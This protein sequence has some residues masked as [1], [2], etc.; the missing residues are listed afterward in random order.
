MLENTSSAFYNTLIIASESCEGFLVVIAKGFNY[1]K[2]KKNFHG[3]FAF[4]LF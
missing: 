3:N 2:K 4:K 1:L